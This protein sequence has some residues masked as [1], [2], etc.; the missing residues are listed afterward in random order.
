[1]LG[2]NKKQFLHIFIIKKSTMGY[3]SNSIITI[4]AILTKKGRELISKG[5]NSFNIT[6]FALSDD[7]IDYSLYNT[8][9]PNGSA[10]Y[11]EAI[12]NMPLLEAFPDETQMLKYKLL[13]L[14]RGVDTIPYVDL[15]V[16]SIS[17]NTSGQ[18]TISPKTKNYSR[19]GDNEKYIFTIFDARLFSSI[20]SSPPQYLGAS[21]SHTVKSHSLS[22][23]AINST[24]ANPRLDTLLRVIGENTGAQITIRVTV[25]S[26]FISTTTTP[27]TL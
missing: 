26:N 1:M 5:D 13:S 19:G 25:T 21:Y 10:Y 23:T 2:F 20:N 22:L 24:G 14:T 8:S 12:E 9:H 4:D 17:L 15:G 27:S 6:Q 18:I 16:N 11:G 3:L 7:E